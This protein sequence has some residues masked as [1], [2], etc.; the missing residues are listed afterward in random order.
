MRCP[1]CGSKEDHVVDTR[2]KEENVRWRRREC[3][4]CN[5]RWNTIETYA[6][7]EV[8]NGR[9]GKNKVQSLHKS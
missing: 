9:E 8:R 1:K 5:F 7:V 4:K 3:L 6:K 2:P